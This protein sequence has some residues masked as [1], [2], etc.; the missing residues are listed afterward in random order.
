MVLM[1]QRGTLLMLYF[2]GLVGGASVT[3]G[4]VSISNIGSVKRKREEDDY[5]IA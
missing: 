5:D 1:S 2:V 4:A 3:A